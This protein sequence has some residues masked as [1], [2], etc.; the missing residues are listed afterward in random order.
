MGAQPRDCTL[1]PPY[2]T[3]VLPIKY[4]YLTHNL[5]AFP[6]VYVYIHISNHGSTATAYPSNHLRW[7]CIHFAMLQIKSVI[8][9]IQ[10]V[11]LHFKMVWHSSR[12]F[13]LLS[14]MV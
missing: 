8:L 4:L 14:R 2:S 1:G 7:L 9:Q 3:R 11:I 13:A 6:F 12:L 5:N 10:S